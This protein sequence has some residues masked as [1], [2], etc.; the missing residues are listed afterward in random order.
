M[1]KQAILDVIRDANTNLGTG[2][3]GAVE[4]N[5]ATLASLVNDLPPADN[6]TR[7]E[8]QPAE[9][10]AAAPTD[11]TYEPTPE[12]SAGASEVTVTDPDLDPEDIEA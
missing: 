1:S 12:T 7:I 9:A 11:D 3:L 5:L 8:D 2:N 6:N 4:E 10:S